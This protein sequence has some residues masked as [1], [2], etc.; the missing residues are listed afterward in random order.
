MGINEKLFNHYK[1]AY[2]FELGRKDQ[3]TS[4]LNLPLTVLTLVGA[5]LAYY[6]E[7]LSSGSPNYLTY[8]I[9]VLIVASIAGMCSS[10]YFLY[11][12]LFGYTYGYVSNTQMIAEHVKAL[13]MYN[14][15]VADD[16]RVDIDKELEAI[17]SEQYSICA[18]EN[19]YNNKRK[20]GYLGSAT[21]SLL[22][23]VIALAITS[24]PFVVLKFA[25]KVS[26]TAR[27]SEAQNLMESDMSKKLDQP[28]ATPQD[29]SR[30]QQ[31]E[32]PEFKQQDSTQSKT[33]LRPQTM[34]KPAKPGIVWLKE[35]QEKNVGTKAPVTQTPKG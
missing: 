25:P 34:K 7:N 16:K 35:S 21:K 30:L 24:V 33:A 11:R 6:L 1:E 2:L 20:L 3:I 12:C 10:V 15:Y 22:F 17:L 18:T 4:N 19:W 27:P 29:S 26:E 32:K 8:I 28:Q 14:E 9:I 13:H 5:L 23:T 31:H